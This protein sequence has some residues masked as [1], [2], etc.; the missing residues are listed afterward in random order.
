MAN[1]NA[2]CNTVNLIDFTKLQEKVN[3]DAIQLQFRKSMVGGLNEEDVSNYILRM[4]NRGHQLEKEIEKGLNEISAYRKSLD[5]AMEE[6]YIL[7]NSLEDY[8]AE[9]ERKDR[10]I[11][12]L[13][14]GDCAEIEHLQSEM[15]RISRER[16]E[17][18]QL[19]SEYTMKF[20]QI[21]LDSDLLKEE[22]NAMKARV[23]NLERDNPDQDHQPDLELCKQKIISLEETITFYT[24]QLEQERTVRENVEKELELEK[25]KVS[26]NEINGFK[27]EV[28][29]IY[30]KIEKLS[31]EA[32]QHVQTYN[33]LLEQ[34]STEQQRA[35][36][37]ENRVAEL[38]EQIQMLKDSIY[39]EQ[40]IFET[41][42]KQIMESR[43]RIQSDIDNI[44]LNS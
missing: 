17:L 13:D 31:D 23:V 7:Q 38:V 27:N 4:E 39:T 42:F 24:R 36:Q 44:L 40:N 14:Q 9:C 5:K 3:R 29:N 1:E 25:A 2:A 12:S 21:T 37:A 8:K 28:I 43:N 33:E 6:N 35:N 11:E 15:G 20:N 26:S 19:L 16:N 18:E 32:E 34:Y 41:Q 10:V 30:K 22:N